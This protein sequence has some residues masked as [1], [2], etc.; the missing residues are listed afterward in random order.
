M[1]T[2][3]FVQ[4]CYTLLDSAVRIGELVRKAKQEGFSSVALTDNQ[5]LYGVPAFLRLCRAEGI[6]G[7]VGMQ[8]TCNYHDES[9][10]FLLLAK[11]NSGYADLLRLS[12]LLCS[13]G[14]VCTKED[15]A[16]FCRHCFL[17]VYGEGGW[18]D[19]ELIADDREKTAEKLRIMKNELPSFDIAL[20]FQEASLWKLRNRTLKR[21][22]ESLS[23]RTVALNKIYYLDEKDADLYQVV[24]GISSGRN[25]TDHT[26]GM[27]RGRHFLSRQEMEELY[28]PEDLERTDEIA[29]QCRADYQL[30]KT[31]LPAFQTPEGYTSET[32][33]PALCTAGLRK[34]LAGKAD[35]V[36]IERLKYE[37]DIIRRMKFEDYFLIVYDFIRYARKN[38]IRVGPGRGSAAGSLVA[39]CLGITQIDPV[40]YNLLFERFL[41]P[42]RISMPDID[43]DI[44][45]DRRDEVIRYVY[46][47]YGPEHV[48]NIIA[49]GTLR[50]K[51]AVRDVGKVMNMNIR[52]VENLS[53]LI[54]NTP[55]ITL[56][57]A[58]SRSPR[59]KQLIDSEKKYAD[60]FRMSVRAEGL[61]RH[62]TIHAAG[63]V[64]SGLPLTDVIPVVRFSEG[65]S[66]SQ[67]SMEFLEERGL[68]KMDF[69][70]LRNL[71]ILDEIVHSVQKENPGFRIETVNLAEPAV[72]RLFREADTEGIFQFESEGMKNLLRK[73]KPENFDDVTAALALYRPASAESIP[74]Y[75]ANKAAPGK[76]VY[77][78]RELEPV[79]K[80]TY[81]VMV[82]QE[83]A[84]KTA[85]T[86]AGFSLGRADV[87]RK[88]MA[89]KNEKEMNALHDE[90]VSGCLKN[91][92]PEAKAEN[93]FSLVSR[94]SGYGF[95]KSH[96]VA[97]GMI[98]YQMAYLK[99]LYPID[100]YCALLNSVI[101]SDDRTS[102][103]V[104]ECRR[105]NIRVQAPDVCRSS[106]RC[107]SENGEIVLPLSIVHSVGTHTASLIAAERE[108]N[109]Q[110]TD[111]FDFTARM[112]VHKTGRQVFESLIDAGAL[113]CFGLGRRT[114]LEGLDDAVR[115]GE[116][117]QIGSGAQITIDLGLVAKPVLISMKDSDEE[118]SRREQNALGFN[119][120]I[121]PIEIMRQKYGIH[122][123][124]LSALRSREGTVNGFACIRNV[125]PHRTKKGDMMAFLR[126]YDETGEADMAVMPRLYRQCSSYLMRGTYIRFCA[127]ISDDR[128]FL[129]DRIEVIAK[130]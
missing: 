107:F 63:I 43:T 37:L 103:Y 95:N 123:P 40:R 73:M 109:G 4:S 23:L 85:Q 48:A 108:E 42:E 25:L 64:M 83:Q 80:E 61:P 116:L 127:K 56:K 57:E 76:I 31:Y 89:K 106:G 81:G 22:A 90:F 86:A 75:L 100:F 32:Y 58:C 65:M 70:G 20:S 50:A 112:L 8:V 5:V 21:I 19:R 102:R 18:F 124:A 113:D 120:G 68:I 27:I 2:H 82:F 69:L 122:D 111:F 1:S 99:A 88:A 49:F 126:I 12:S 118:K 92:I 117:V 41:N 44:A 79:L 91:G 15:L 13:E 24:R 121:Q 101:G 46:E 17:I 7:I 71:S 97:Y 53:R 16:R 105:K 26:L 28:D 114:M 11:D 96:A 130:K 128:S 87:M 29:R 125:H 38:G 60:L 62:A 9:V 10:P 59:M 14:Y 36:Y 45:D 66:T 67:Y 35:P 74:E 47:K 54:P 119:L 84:M 39:Y 30:P 77:P 3:L 52:D 34:R 104:N 94:F 72:F 98:A 93:L 110:F 6:H 78:L 55:G 51:Q 115:Y 33:L 129:A